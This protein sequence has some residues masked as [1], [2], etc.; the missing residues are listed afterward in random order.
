MGTIIQELQAE[1]LLLKKK[2]KEI[3]EKQLEEGLLLEQIITDISTRFVNLKTKRLN[4]E[5]NRALSEI[6]LFTGTDRVYV[7]LFDYKNKEINNTN[8]WCAPGINKEIDNLKNLPLDFFPWWN[9]QLSLNKEIN[10]YSLDDLPSDAVTEKEILS[11]QSILSLLVV[12]VIHSAELIGFIGFDSVRKQKK[13]TK[14]EVRILRLLAEIFGSAVN[15]IVIEQ[16]L[17]DSLEKYRLLFENST[18][19]ILIADCNGKYYFANKIAGRNVNMSPQDIPG[20]SVY[21]FFPKQQADF[22]VSNTRKVIKFKKRSE[23]ENLI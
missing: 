5:I 2:L 15:K 22:F 19:A 11:R 10:L 13:W 9:K 17:T 20:K 4:F 14:R 23:H 3:K 8:E 6:G 21:D 1:N 18:A 7:F 12:P 16:K